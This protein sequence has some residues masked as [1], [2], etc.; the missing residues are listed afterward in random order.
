MKRKQEGEWMKC[1]NSNCNGKI[2]MEKQKTKKGNFYYCKKCGT[3][4]YR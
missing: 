2:D 3:V 1:P 4:I